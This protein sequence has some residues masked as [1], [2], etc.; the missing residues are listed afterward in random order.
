MTHLAEMSMDDYWPA[1]H[2]G[3]SWSQEWNR[4]VAEI[5]DSAYRI[6]DAKGSTC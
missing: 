5:L 1:C 4:I 2:R 6:T 3:P